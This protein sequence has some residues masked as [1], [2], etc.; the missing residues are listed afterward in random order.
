LI[1]ENSGVIKEEL[2]FSLLD[3]SILG[4]FEKESSLKKKAF[5]ANQWKKEI[6]EKMKRFPKSS[7]LN[8]R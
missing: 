1:F 5:A 2:R 7:M 3:S 4:R 6:V 8:Y